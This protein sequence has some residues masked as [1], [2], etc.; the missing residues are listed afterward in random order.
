MLGLLAISNVLTAGV[1]TVQVFLD[2]D[3]LAG[4]NGTLGLTIPTLSS[5]SSEEEEE[6][7]DDDEDEDEEL[8]E[9]LLRFDF[10]LFLDLLILDFFIYSFFSSISFSIS[11]FFRF[12]N[13][14]F[15]ILTLS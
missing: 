13:L 12:V 7:E 4:V 10:L 15:T 6:K 11:T 3:L 9:Y 2:I 8:D 14:L 5:S 1:E